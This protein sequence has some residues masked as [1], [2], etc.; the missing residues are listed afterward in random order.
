MKQKLAVR[1]KKHRSYGTNTCE[2]ETKQA[3]CVKQRAVQKI[4]L[5]FNKSNRGQTVRKTQAAPCLVKRSCPSPSSGLQ[6]ESAKIAPTFTKLSENGPS[7]RGVAWSVKNNK[8]KG[9]A[10]VKCE[11]NNCR[12]AGLPQVHSLDRSVPIAGPDPS[13]EPS[14]GFAI[15]YQLMLKN[16]VKMLTDS[17]K[18]HWIYLWLSMIWQKPC[19]V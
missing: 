17:F 6:P 7:S 12:R 3:R 13:K 18:H 14:P 15:G 1:S 5:P 19:F 2:D 4:R 8:S 10:G 11:H 9:S 16:S